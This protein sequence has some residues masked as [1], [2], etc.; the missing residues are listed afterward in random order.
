MAMPKFNYSQQ[1]LRLQADQAWA[2]LSASLT[3]EQGMSQNHLAG[4]S[5]HDQQ[6]FY[7]MAGLSYKLNRKDGISG[8]ISYSDHS[9][10]QDVRVRSVLAGLTGDFSLHR[11]SRCSFSWRSGYSL[12]EYYLDRNIFEAGITQE[13]SAG[14]LLDIRARYTL[15]R[16]SL[17]RREMAAMVNLTLPFDLPL[18]AKKMTGAVRGRIIHLDGHSCQGLIL[19]LGTA[20]A[21]AD[22]DGTFR[23]PHIEPGSYPLLI[24]PRSKAL[25]DVIVEKLPPVSIIAG[26]ETQV[27]LTL[28]QAAEFIAKLISTL[29]GQALFRRISPTSLW[30]CMTARR[31]FAFIA[32]LQAIV[33]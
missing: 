19:H 17:D 5:G 16:N 23:F 20:V 25:H 3:T 27:N 22:A 9:R 30:N 10:Y 29:S 15:L 18:P 31:P 14:K 28:C 32:A 8:T 12:E 13:F 21:M 7:A 24:D 4:F 33:A 6:M 1:S 11:H 2:R 26:T